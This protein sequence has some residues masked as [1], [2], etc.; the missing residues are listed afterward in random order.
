MIIVECFQR[1]RGAVPLAIRQPAEAH[2]KP[3]A[4]TAL[5][6]AV[7]H[8]GG[9]PAAK[10]PVQFFKVGQVVFVARLG[11]DLALDALQHLQDGLAVPEQFG[12]IAVIRPR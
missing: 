7:L 8:R 12:N 9:H 6:A 2:I 1:L 5:K 3:L 10:E 11:A 4:K